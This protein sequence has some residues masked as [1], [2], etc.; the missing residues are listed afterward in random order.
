MPCTQTWSESSHLLTSGSFLIVDLRCPSGL[1]SHSLGLLGLP[2]TQFCLDVELLSLATAPQAPCMT[3]K[4]TS[5]KTWTLGGSNTL[6]CIF[7]HRCEQYQNVFKSIVTRSQLHQERSL[8]KSMT[9]N[10]ASLCLECQNK[11]WS[12]T[13]IWREQ[14]CENLKPQWWQC[15]QIAHMFYRKFLLV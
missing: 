2:A 5:R 9:H 6:E 13:S 15:P 4:C 14:T 10:Y 12:S 3:Q 11:L 1:C 7:I 8:I